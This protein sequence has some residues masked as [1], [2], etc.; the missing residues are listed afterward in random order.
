MTRVATIDVGTNTAQ[1]LIADVH[2]ETMTPHFEESRVVR[3]GEGVDAD[4]QVN[5][6]AMA[7]L[8]AALLDYRAQAERAGIAAEAV[9]I[10]ATSA[11]RDARNQAELI[12][13]V[14]RETGLTYTI[15]SGDEEARWSFAGAVSALG[16]MGGSCAVIDIGGGST[17]LIVGDAATGALAYRHSY[18]M[19]TVRIAERFLASQPPSSNAVAS[20]ERFVRALLQA[21]PPPIAPDVPFVG[22]AGTARVLGALHAQQI[23]APSP[24]LT[25]TR[26][27]VTSWRDRL[28]DLPFGD[29]LALHPAL[30]TGRADVFPAGLL[31]LAAVMQH[32]NLPSCRISPRG[33]KHGLAMQLMQAVR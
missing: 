25:L 11:S 12:D 27:E 7:R 32:L 5:A 13:Y 17:E 10:G 14:R 8:R 2:D 9:Y 3:L 22:A 18:D 1:L 16:D 24:D 21:T 30:L 28:L 6:A 31:I 33:L 29:V 4:R 20:A 15:I 19:G 26:A 23:G